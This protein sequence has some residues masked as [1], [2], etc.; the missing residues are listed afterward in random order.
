M[1]GTA[2]AAN[3]EEVLVIL[4]SMKSVASHFLEKKISN[5]NNKNKKFNQNTDKNSIAIK[6]V[7][8]SDQLKGSQLA[9]DFCKFSMSQDKH[10]LALRA[11]VNV[12]NIS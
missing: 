11:R 5:H 10:L 3:D 9:N 8:A 12:K 6:N 4:R 1:I 2:T 7:F